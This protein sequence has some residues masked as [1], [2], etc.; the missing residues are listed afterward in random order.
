MKTYLI[1]FMLLALVSCEGVKPVSIHKVGK[2]EATQVEK[3]FTI[4]GCTVYKFEDN[5]R[6]VHFTNCQGSTHYQESCGKNC[7]RK[8]SVD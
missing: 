2:N 7:T 5:G 8:V 6:T 1:L 4:D 3:L